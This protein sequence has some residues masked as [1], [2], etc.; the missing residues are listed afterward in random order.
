MSNI[1]SPSDAPMRSEVYSL[2]LAQGIYAQFFQAILLRELVTRFCGIELSFVVAIAV[3]LLW[4]ALGCALAGNFLK[5]ASP[6]ALGAGAL[7]SILAPLAAVATVALAAVA[8]PLLGSGLE[9][10]LLFCFIAPLPFGLLNGAI[11]GLLVTFAPRD[12]GALCYATAA[13]GSI[14]G[15]LVFSLALAQFAPPLMVLG[16]FGLALPLMG[17]IFVWRMSLPAPLKVFMRFLAL[18]AIGLS[19][20][21]SQADHELSVW[22]WTSLQ[23]GFLFEQ[24]VETPSGRVDLL[25]SLPLQDE[26]TNSGERPW[27]SAR[28]KVYRDASPYA[29]MP[30]N[31]DL[32]CPAALF[33]ALQPNRANLSILLVSS[34][35]SPLA[36]ILAG[37]PITER[38]ELLCADSSLVALS[39]NLE[40]LPP[41]GEGFSVINAEPRAYIELSRQKSPATYDLIIVADMRPETLAGNRFFTVEFFRAVAGRLRPGGVFVTTMSPSNDP[42]SAAMNST[43]LRTLRKVFPRLA[44]SPSDISL[45]AAGEKNLTSDLSTLDHRLSRLLKDCEKFPEAMF[46]ILFSQAQQ[47]REYQALSNCES[48][49]LLNT[50]LHPAQPFLFLRHHSSVFSGAGSPLSC[51]AGTLARQW[52]LIFCVGFAAYLFLRFILSRRMDS[53]LL[54]SSFEN[55][56]YAMGIAL[57]LLFVYQCKSA[58][59]YRDLAAALGLFIGGAAL[60]AWG[61]D[62]SKLC[63]RAIRLAA[64]LIPLFVPF[65]SWMPS[66][67]V[68]ILI[69][70]LLTLSGIAVGLAYAEFLFRST[71]HQGAWLWCMELA[72]GSA[73]CLL[74]TFFLLPA[75]GIAPCIILLSLLR[76]PLLLGRF[77]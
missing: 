52:L 3:S 69:F 29:E 37:L 56:F 55:G 24:S 39:R 42:A 35:F 28:L 46:S 65:L 21:A 45:V 10:L 8:P 53:R 2:L 74:L 25:Q 23:P 49:T 20:R 12:E 61:R 19:W 22:K 6:Q 57:L 9:E 11:C 63:E 72:G 47:Y 75:G 60:G 71:V 33:A 54:F 64:F 30:V 40:L 32:W 26:A 41:E 5:A 43:L 1:E 51:L 34:P 14:L 17:G 7:L 15:G 13:F 68:Q 48:S 70:L 18:I 62:R 36:D 4:T 31:G 73:A 38:I 50:D 59:L 76:L 16:A 66:G 67:Q 58:T 77:V 44:S 27:E